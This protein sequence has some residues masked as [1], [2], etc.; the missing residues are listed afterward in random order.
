V[1]VV[2]VIARSACDEAIQQSIC[3]I[4][5]LLRFARN[6]GRLAS[7]LPWGEVGA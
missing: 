4:D 3:R 2:F 7:P 6:D 5:G 1:I